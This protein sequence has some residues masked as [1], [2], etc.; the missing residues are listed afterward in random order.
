MVRVHP[1]LTDNSEVSYLLISLPLAPQLLDGD[2]YV[3]EDQ[4]PPQ[5]RKARRP[6]GPTLRSLVKLALA[7]ESAEEMGKRL[8]RRF[9]RQ[10]QR[11]GIAPPGRHRVEGELADQLD[12]LLTQD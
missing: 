10:Q 12:R 5:V 6:R 3:L 7:C 11:Q 1:I 4:L 2:R 8:R 9:E